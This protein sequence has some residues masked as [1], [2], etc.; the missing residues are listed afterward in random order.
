MFARALDGTS[1]RPGRTPPQWHLV[2][3]VGTTPRRS[4]RL[5]RRSTWRRVP[6]KTPAEGLV[7]TLGIGRPSCVIFSSCAVERPHLSMVSFQ[8]RMAHNAAS[9]GV[10]TVRG[11]WTGYALRALVDDRGRPPPGVPAP[12]GPGPRRVVS[13]RFETVD[14]EEAHLGEFV[15]AG[16]PVALFVRQLQRCPPV[17]AQTGAYANE[18]CAHPTACT[19]EPA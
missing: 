3:A 18:Q 16:S 15:R 19:R 4:Q 2:R 17:T 5:H 12:G 10:S 8:H 6:R 13:A 1:R 14:H 11:R 7:D 9:G